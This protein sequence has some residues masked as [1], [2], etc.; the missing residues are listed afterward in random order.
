MNKIPTYLL[1]GPL[2]SGKTTILKEVLSHPHFTKSIVIENEYAD[3]NIDKQLLTDDSHEVK[4]MDVSGGCICCTSG[5]DLFDTFQTI[6]KEQDVEQVF[7]ETTGVASSVQLIK[8]MMLSREF[9]D[10]FI[11]VKNLLVIDALEENVD[12]LKQEKMLDLIMADLVILHKTDLVDDKKLAD[13]RSFLQSLPQL[14]F[15]ETNHGKLDPTQIISD[16][17]SKALTT[18]LDHLDEVS[19]TSIDHSQDILY[20]V[21]YPTK[22]VEVEEL[23]SLIQ[24]AQD[25]GASIR[26]AKGTFTLPSGDQVSLNGTTNDLKMQELTTKTKQDNVLVFIGNNVTKETIKPIVDSL[27]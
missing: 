19:D 27:C 8:Q 22:T 21:V 1:H 15:I 3:Y 24:K 12:L 13:F 2:G 14:V 9:D 6:A 23:R 10:D 26:R 25:N 17:K 11:L 20:Q 7:I 4:I 16:Q 5:R 18:L